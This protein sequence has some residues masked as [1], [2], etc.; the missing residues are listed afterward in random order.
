MGSE[1]CI[2]DS[3]Y[4]DD[5]EHWLKRMMRKAR[6]MEHHEAPKSAE[7]LGTEKH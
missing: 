7:Q 6:G 3:T 2:R 4:I 5:L 1:M